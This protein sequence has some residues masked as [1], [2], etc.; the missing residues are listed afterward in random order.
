MTVYCVCSYNIY[1]G[2][3]A[4]SA[5]FSTEEK[6]QAYVNGLKPADDQNGYSIE[7]YEVDKLPD[8]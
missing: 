8:L 7:E 3:Y 5:V 6:A 2:T 4:P 1:E